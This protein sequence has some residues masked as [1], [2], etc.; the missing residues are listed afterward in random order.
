[1]HSLL[2][3]RDHPLPP[4]V[5]AFVAFLVCGLG[6]PRGRCA[7][8]PLPTDKP[9]LPAGL[10]FFQTPDFTAPA[11]S[12]DGKNIAFIARQNG[13]A[14]LFRLDRATGQLQ[15]LFTAGEGEVA[16]FW[17]IGSQRMLIAGLGAEG[18]EYF[19]MDLDGSPPRPVPSLKQ[20]P[21]GWIKP[22]PDDHDH[23]MAL[24]EFRG[25]QYLARIDLRTGRETK[26]EGYPVWLENVVLSAGGEL[27]AKF[28]RSGSKWHV[29]WRAS[30]KQGWHA[31][32]GSN[33]VWPTFLPAAI[34]AD[35]RQ[36][37]VNANDQGD[38]SAF[39]LL[40]PETDQRTL[41]ARR[42]GHDAYGLL[43]MAPQPSP[44]GLTYYNSGPQEAIYL[45]QAMQAFAS[46]LDRSLPGT[47][48][49][50]TSSS[51][52]GTVR[53]IEAWPPGCPSSF[54]LFEQAHHKLSLLGQERPAL[55]PEQLGQVHY[56]RFKARDG[57]AESGYVLLPPAAAGRKPAPVIVMPM[58]YVGEQA[59][60]ADYF[61]AQDQ[62]LAGRGFAVARFAV[63]GSV[64]FGREFQKA[65]EFELGGKIVQ[66]LED[67]VTHIAQ[68]GLIDPQRV[69]LFGTGLPGLFA[70]RTAAVS[71]AFRAVV[72]YNVRC[73]LSAGSI[74]W[75]SSSRADTATIIQKVGDPHA[76]YAMM[77]QFKPEA[78]MEKLTA[79]ALLVCSTWYGS[80][81]SPIDAGQIRASFEKHHKSYE[82]YQLDF[83]DAEHRP[84]A[85]YQA[86][87]YAKIADY[88]A[89]KLN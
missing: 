52:D 86:Q 5:W 9:G 12:P 67:G 48:H 16:R 51:T 40:D 28:W 2:R 27:R 65:G 8:Q 44:I 41:L 55:K 24:L 78:F 22:L 81:D 53:I 25:E 1:M 35:D 21:A 76:A 46:V 72:A 89:E 14:S 3:S 23:V 39:M 50:I 37:I 34:A 61:T 80:E 69:A 38:S 11:I 13:H 29:A 43:W 42:A 62:Y 58:Q 31:I 85:E 15:G 19:V 79:P 47:I 71:Q 49:R 77:S 4:Y 18:R 54:Y 60:A 17:W 30:A 57:L 84:L 74:G 83:H 33:E 66:D 63:R 82:W 88:L 64:G 87:L 7:A 56:F 70:L 73:D 75:L 59:A 36:I 6:V 45:D 26:L 10:A 32:E 68:E 20:A